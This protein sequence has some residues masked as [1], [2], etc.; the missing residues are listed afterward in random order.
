[1]TAG[2]KSRLLGFHPGY[3]VPPRHSIVC[4]LVQLASPCQYKRWMLFVDDIEHQAVTFLLAPVP[5]S[6]CT[7]CAGADDF[8]T[9]YNSAYK[10]FGHFLT[11]MI[12]VS[13][14]SLPLIMA[15]TGLIAPAACW[16]SMTGG[17]LV[18]GTILVFSGVFAPT[19][20]EY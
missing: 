2:L 11:S 16:M 18:Y 15:H 7:R 9:E 17:A 8:S 6:I 3:R 12:V 1:M 10:D 13:A 14:F 20:D 4:P 5:N 19:E